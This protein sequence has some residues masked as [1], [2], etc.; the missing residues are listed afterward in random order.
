MVYTPAQMLLLVASEKQHT[1]DIYTE[2]I[3]DIQ[4]GGTGRNYRDAFF[5]E[6]KQF[7]IEMTAMN[8]MA[9]ERGIKLD[10]SEKKKLTEAA[11]EFYLSSVAPEEKL[12][13]LGSDETAEMFLQYALAMKLRSSMMQDRR[14]EISESEAK[15]VRVQ[16]LIAD[17]E[18]T[19]SQIYE[20][21]AEG[22]DFY[23]LAKTY[24]TE[25]SASLKV[26]RGEL[27]APLEEV[28]FS[29]EDGQVSEPMIHEGRY[30]IFK[31]VDSYDEKETAIRR[32]GLQS[33]K[34]RSIVREAYTGY[35]R[36]HRITMEDALWDQVR[37][38][39]DFSY[40]GEDFFSAV[41]E[42]MQDESL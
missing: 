23:A 33:E 5:D 20:R 1:E 18:N 8:G 38:A 2:K 22:A 16:Q 30:Y 9:A 24:G 40:S 28:V 17:D 27:P 34:L 31:A 41:R 26:G 12:A 6:M 36:K 42:A 11:E 39:S 7:F 25:R 29:L 21:A 15:V 19:A 4:I 3:W 35:I 10:S 32:Q 14:A 37:E 13:G